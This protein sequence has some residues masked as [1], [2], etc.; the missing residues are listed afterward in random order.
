[1]KREFDEMRGRHLNVKFESTLVSDWLGLRALKRHQLLVNQTVLLSFKTAFVT[2]N[3]LSTVVFYLLFL[4]RCFC[5]IGHLYL[6]F[7]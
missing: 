4:N 2:L 7:V 3:A 6:K 1:M 5:L